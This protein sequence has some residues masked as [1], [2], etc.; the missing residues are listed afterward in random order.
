MQTLPEE[1]KF[2]SLSAHFSANQ[3]V[4]KSCARRRSQ[5]VRSSGPI[6]KTWLEPSGNKLP[7]SYRKG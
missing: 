4:P 3:I 7:N 6:I 5:S 2:H 1:A